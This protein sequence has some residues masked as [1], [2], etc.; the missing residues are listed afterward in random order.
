VSPALCYRANG[1]ALNPAFSFFTLSGISLILWTHPDGRVLLTVSEMGKV[2]EIEGFVLVFC[3]MLTMI[4]S[5]TIRKEDT[6]DGEMMS[7]GHLVLAAFVAV[8]MGG[9]FAALI[10]GFKL[11]LIYWVSLILHVQGTLKLSFKEMQVEGAVN[12]LAAVA[13]C[14][15]GVLAV[16]YPILPSF[17]SYPSTFNSWNFRVQGHQMLAWAFAH[18]AFLGLLHL[19]KRRMFAHVLQA[20]DPK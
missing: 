12:F 15:L 16:K 14:G 9:G 17:G 20:D 13:F 1:A 7:P 2:M 3:S 8:V 5:S 11:T 18:F 4:I 19:C 6:P 10:G